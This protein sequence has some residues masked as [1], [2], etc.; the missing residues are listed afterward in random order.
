MLLNLYALTSNP[1]KKI[2]KFTLSSDIQKEITESL[3]NLKNNF[4][5]GAEIISF[6]GK[7]K[8]DDGELLVIEG[9]DDIDQLSRAIKS[10]LSIEPISPTEESMKEIKAI[11]SGFE[12]EDG[13]IVILLQN[14]DKRKI[15][16]TNGFC[17]YHSGDVYKKI[18][19]IAI[20]IDS[21]LT[22]TIK[23]NNLYFKNF[24]NTRQIFDLSDYYKEATNDDIISFADNSILKV[25]SVDVL[26][27]MSDSW[28]RKK[29]S[30]V[31]QS[32][33]LSIVPINEIK[34]IAAEFNIKLETI[35]EIIDGNESEK[36]KFPTEKV[37]IKKLLRFLDEDYY[38]SPL[39]KNSFISN[40]KRL[41]D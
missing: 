18:E 14:F 12:E 4:F 27:S 33:I 24:H 39:S 3:L 19:G 5:S 7:Y 10:P 30:L 34:A 21:K 26:V 22:A 41:A 6:D 40:S 35:T 13:N 11:F 38:K 20:T 1:S 37:D 36:I 29:I 28:M 16:S 31:Q 9:F 23:D 17:I 25:E 32:N 15:I 8:P 2:V